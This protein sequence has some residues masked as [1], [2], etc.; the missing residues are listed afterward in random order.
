MRVEQIMCRQLVCIGPHE[1]LE[2]ARRLM[3]DHEVE[4]L[5]VVAE[6]T[7]LGILSR[8]DIRMPLDWP[9]VIRWMDELEVGEFMD[10]RPSTVPPTAS[11]ADAAALMC[12]RSIDCVV[13][14]DD[15]R[16]VGVVTRGDVLRALSPTLDEPQQLL[17]M[18]H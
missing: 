12:A 2:T 11:A 9:E 18:V 15:D 10:R 4:Q 17:R 3:A 7:L 14:V 16:L 5:P 13:V 8:A 1:P 6:D